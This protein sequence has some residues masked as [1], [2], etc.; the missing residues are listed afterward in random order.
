MARG[1]FEPSDAEYAA[2]HEILILLPKTSEPLNS[3]ALPESHAAGI[4]NPCH[5]TLRCAPPTSPAGRPSRTRNRRRP[6]QVR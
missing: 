2:A 1:G 6:A 4:A 3:V 5:G